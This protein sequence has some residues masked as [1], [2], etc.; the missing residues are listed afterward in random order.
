MMPFVGLT[1]AGVGVQSPQTTGAEQ[2]GPAPVVVR[3]SLDGPRTDCAAR[4]LY[5]HHSFR[6]SALHPARRHATELA[7]GR[8]R[9]QWML[10]RYAG[11]ARPLDVAHAAICLPKGAAVLGMRC[12]A[13]QKIKRQGGSERPAPRTIHR[14][15]SGQAWEAMGLPRRYMRRRLLF[16]RRKAR[17]RNSGLRVAFA[18]APALAVHSRSITVIREEVDGLAWILERSADANQAAEAGQ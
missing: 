8:V 14:W 12:W 1:A 11:M 3:V 10:V 7:R 16:A 5:Q 9:Q 18:L 13:A 4:S 6:Q 15:E 2:F 17:H